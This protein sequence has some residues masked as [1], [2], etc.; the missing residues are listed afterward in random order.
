MGGQDVPGVGLARLQTNPLI[1]WRVVRKGQLNADVRNADVRMD[2]VLR[3]VTAGVS[4]GFVF[5]VR[6]E[7]PYRRTYYDG[8]NN[9]F[10]ESGGLYRY[11]ISRA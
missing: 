9:L 5:S 4:G 11:Y 2:T 10:T 7:A 6:R 8:A 3:N 1:L